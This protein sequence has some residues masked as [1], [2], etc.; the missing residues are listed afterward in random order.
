MEPTFDWERAA[1]EANADPDYDTPAAATA[2]MLEMPPV[3]PIA[4]PGDNNAD[5]LD[6]PSPDLLKDKPRKPNGLKFEKKVLNFFNFLTRHFLAHEGTIADAAA[7]IQWG[8]KTARAIGDVAVDYP[9]IAKLVDGGEFIGN[10]SALEALAELAPL[11]LQMARNHEEAMAPQPRVLRIPY[12]K[13]GFKLPRLGIRLGLFRAATRNPESLIEHVFNDPDILAALA[14][15]GITVA[16][17]A[18]N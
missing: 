14:K 2:R 8:P 10:N 16:D 11:V 15:R 9:I 18:A 5:D 3:E 1:A 4:E 6:R 17:T 12:T 13:L 7:L